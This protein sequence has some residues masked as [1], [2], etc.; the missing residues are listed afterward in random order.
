[1]SRDEVRTAVNAL[2]GA[3]W[4]FLAVNLVLNNLVA[5]CIATAVTDSACFKNTLFGNAQVYSTYTFL[6]CNLFSQEGN[7]L[8]KVKIVDV[9]T[10]FEPSFLYSYECSSKLVTNYTRIYIYMYS[11]FI[12][13]VVLKVVV[14][15]LIL[16][17]LRKMKFENNSS[18]NSS[19]VDATTGEQQHLTGPPTPMCC[20]TLQDANKFAQRVIYSMLPKLSLA[21][22]EFDDSDKFARSDEGNSN[23]DVDSLIQTDTYF[24]N[25]ISMVALLV[26][27][28]TAAPLLAIVISLGLLFCLLYIYIFFLF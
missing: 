23:N 10:S 17:Y 13:Y 19:S 16:R 27:F 4:S 1:M 12:V 26:T 6:S 11:F 3:E 21:P 18:N 5:P 14:L 15:R 22:K 2:F 8:G 24:A 28:G 7:C 25:L 9:T 20:C